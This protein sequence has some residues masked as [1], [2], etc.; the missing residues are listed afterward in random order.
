VSQSK[1]SIKKAYYLHIR[2]LCHIQSG[3]PDFA[4]VKLIVARC[5]SDGCFGDQVIRRSGVRNDGGGSCCK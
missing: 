3:V 4:V 2:T 1:I 5:G